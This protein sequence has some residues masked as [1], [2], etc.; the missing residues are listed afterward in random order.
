[1]QCSKI[2][3][4]IIYQEL[5]SMNKKPKYSF[6][7]LPEQVPS[8]GSRF[9]RNFFKKLYLVNGWHFDG[10]F[11]NLPK[12]VAIVLPHTSNYDAIYGFLAMLGLGLKVTVFGKDTLFRPPLK[13]LLHWVGAIPVKRDTPQGLTKQIVDII[14]TKD[15]IWI[16]LA[17]E[18]TR[19]SPEQIRSGFYHIATGAKIPI[20]MFALDY[21]M[22]AIHCLGV[23][24]PTGDYAQDLDKILTHYAGHF[25]PKNLNRL[26]KPLKK[27]L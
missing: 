11:P 17:P 9:S 25:Y 26:A 1:M 16:A 15:K 14:S 20:V 7:T 4:L 22:K 3:N 2:L 13:G 6:P 23:L 19:K 27:L 21:K 18:G 12:A 10:D 5:R 8:R 24:Y